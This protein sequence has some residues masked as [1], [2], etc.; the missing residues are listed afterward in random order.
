MDNNMNT[1]R[2]LTCLLAAA[3]LC[4]SAVLTTSCSKEDVNVVRPQNY[5]PPAQQGQND[6]TITD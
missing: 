1:M 6:S 2:T 5:N 4:G 3:L